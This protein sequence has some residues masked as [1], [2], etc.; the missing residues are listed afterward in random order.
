MRAL[1]RYGNCI[2]P[3]LHWPAT[4]HVATLRPV[5]SR[6]LKLSAGM[7]WA[8]ALGPATADAAPPPT[9]AGR[10]AVLPLDAP[11]AA[12][13]E[14]QALTEAML[15][16]LGRGN[17]ATTTVKAPAQCGPKCMANLAAEVDAKHLVSISVEKKGPDW[18]ITG[19][20]FD[21]NGAGSGVNQATCEICGAAELASLVEDVAA[22]LAA[23]VAAAGRSATLVLAG[24]PEGATVWVDGV[25]V[26]V[27]PFEGTFAPGKHEI[28]ITAKGHS[29]QKRK[30]TGKEG[31]SETLQYTL[32][33]DVRGVDRVRR[34]G[35]DVTG[36]TRGEVLA[37]PFGWL[38]IGFGAATIGAGAVMI[39]L[40]GRNHAQTCIPGIVDADGDCPF[41]YQT[42]V[43]GAIAAG[44]GAAILGAG[45]AGVVIGRKRAKQH[46]AKTEPPQ[47]EARLDFGAGSLRLDVRF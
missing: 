14:G 9:E 22:G 7:A 35:A 13:A 24:E 29:E 10:I 47:A 1:T 30:W 32:G 4:P 33:K 18:A 15:S 39:A 11:D 42:M 20:I 6:A 8:L 38:G 19:R 3:K 43:P 36:L 27:T 31:V 40:N 17:A 23:E 28:L 34:P 26:G 12:A 21:R 16:G 44:V 41:T 25:E 2:G 46:A 45:I 37:E 5:P